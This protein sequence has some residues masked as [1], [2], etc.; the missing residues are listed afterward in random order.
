[1]LQNESVSSLTMASNGMQSLTI[2]SFNVY[3]IDGFVIGDVTEI[4]KLELTSYR[5]LSP[6]RIITLD[7]KKTVLVN[8][9]NDNNV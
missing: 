5:E 4:V 9:Y 2:N 7:K 3:N 8:A 6:D 1:M